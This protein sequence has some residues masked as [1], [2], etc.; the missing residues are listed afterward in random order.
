VICGWHGPGRETC[1]MFVFHFF[2]NK[3]LCDEDDECGRS[4][5][6]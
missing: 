1:S 5:G 2:S 4:C 3:E 6:V